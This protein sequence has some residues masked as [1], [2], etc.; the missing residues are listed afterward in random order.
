LRIFGGTHFEYSLDIVVNRLLR[1]GKTKTKLRRINVLH[2]LCLHIK[3]K[4]L[5]VLTPELLVSITGL[6]MYAVKNIKDIIDK[7]L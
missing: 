5:K 6:K 1:Y 4:T 2:K 7:P 3:I